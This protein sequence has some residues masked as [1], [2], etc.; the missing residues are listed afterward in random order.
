MNLHTALLTS[1][2]EIEKPFYSEIVSQICIIN[3]TKTTVV[4][5]LLQWQNHISSLC[6]NNALTGSSINIWSV[7][8]A[9]S[10][11]YVGHTIRKFVAM[12]EQ[13]QQI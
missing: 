3:Q 2:K 1:E 13:F 7:S 11:M 8:I 6:I 12:Y 4:L 9:M 10:Y 5:Y